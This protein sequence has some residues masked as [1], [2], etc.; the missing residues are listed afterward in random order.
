MYEEIDVFQ[1]LGRLINEIILHEESDED[2]F[3]K[4]SISHFDLYCQSMVEIGADVSK[5]LKFEEK[6]GKKWGNFS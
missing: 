2:P 3:N 4:N 5:V 6:V 1:S